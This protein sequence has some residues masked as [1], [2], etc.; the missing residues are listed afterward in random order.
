MGQVT[1]DALRDGRVAICV[2]TQLAGARKLGSHHEPRRSRER[3]QPWCRLAG[4]C[5][6]VE[7]GPLELPGSVPATRRTREPEATRPAAEQPWTAAVA[8]GCRRATLA[9]RQSCQRLSSRP[10][11][12]RKIC[13]VL[14]RRP[15]RP[16]AI[17]PTLSPGR[18][19]SAADSP[20]HRHGETRAGTR[21]SDAVPAPGQGLAVVPASVPGSRDAASRGWGRGRKRGRPGSL[22]PCQGARRVRTRTIKFATLIPP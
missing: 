14:F 17:C 4:L 20:A 9:G 19:W 5:R 16:G 10:D 2:I 15:E 18:G 22:R 1:V 6:A 7:T 8:R 12:A 21:A 13:Q 3:K 11:R